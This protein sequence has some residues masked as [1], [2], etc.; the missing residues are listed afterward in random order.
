MS[1]Y[2]K[3]KCTQCGHPAHR[4]TGTHVEDSRTAC[5]A[6]GILRCTCDRF[7]DPTEVPV[8]DD[9]R[10]LGLGGP[11]L[12]LGADPDDPLGDDPPPGDDI[13]GNDG[14]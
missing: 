3:L 9:E 7:H 10:A 4:H 5:R 2:D 6:K 8:N 12:G 14:S 1:L 13:L 11:E